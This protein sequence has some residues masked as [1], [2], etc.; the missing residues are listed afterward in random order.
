MNPVCQVTRASTFG[1]SDI[2][3]PSLWNLL[4][5]TLV[6]P[7]YLKLLLNFCNMCASLPAGILYEVPWIPSI[8]LRDRDRVILPEV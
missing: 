6:A 4:R 5:V 2:Y 7:R 3:R 8:C 1:M